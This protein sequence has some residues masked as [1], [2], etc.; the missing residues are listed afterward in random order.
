MRHAIL[1]LALFIF[2][3]SSACNT[4]VV[5]RED[6]D[7]QYSATAVTLSDFSYKVV[8]YYEEQKLSISPD[9]DAKQFFEVLEKKYPDQVR[10]KNVR[11]NYK[12]SVRSVDGGYSAMLC[13][14]STNAKIMEDLSCHLNRVEI[15][16]WQSG[17]STPCDFESDWKTYCN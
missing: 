7:K 14:P 2:I 10:V 15:R 6:L 3:L 5:S 13:D 4:L 1:A 17:L 11:E 12:V 9:F 16:T 8:G